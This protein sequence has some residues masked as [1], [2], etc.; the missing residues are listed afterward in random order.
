M[1]AAWVQKT[2]QVTAPARGCHLI[3]RDIVKGCPEIASFKVGL[4]HL[5]L[6]HTSASLSINENADPT[7]RVDMEG[8]LNR[9]VPESWHEGPEAFFQHTMEG[10]DDMTGVFVA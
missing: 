2:I 3:T 8:A 7:V 1:A 6:Q 5:F 10:P 9:I 4:V